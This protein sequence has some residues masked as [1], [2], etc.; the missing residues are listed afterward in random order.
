MD[1]KLRSKNIIVVGGASGIGLS[2]AQ[3]LLDCG[4]D[5][6]ILASRS[7]EKQKKAINA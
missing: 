4:A 1:I 6:I 5:N 3:M 2:T 7:R